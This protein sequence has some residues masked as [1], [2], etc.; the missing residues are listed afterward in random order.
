[1]KDSSPQ[2]AAAAARRGRTGHPSPSQQQQ[3]RWTP[4]LQLAAGEEKTV[5]QQRQL[6]LGTVKSE[7]IDSNINMTRRFSDYPMNVGHVI[8][9][10]PAPPPPPPPVH[11]GSTSFLNPPALVMPTTTTNG[12]QRYH[13]APSSLLHSLCSLNNY[14]DLHHGSFPQA[15]GTALDSCR[16]RISTSLMPP[17]FFSDG[18]LPAITE[19]MIDTSD[20]KLTNTGTATNLETEFDQYMCNMNPTD[21]G[22]RA[23]L[24]AAAMIEQQSGKSELANWQVPSDDVLLPEDPFES[25]FPSLKNRSSHNNNAHQLRDA[26]R[27]LDVDESN[28]CSPTTLGMAVH[29]MMSSED[30]ESNISGT[31]EVANYGSYGSQAPAM[32]SRDDSFL[33]SDTLTSLEFLPTSHTGDMSDKHHYGIELGESKMSCETTQGPMRSRPAGAVAGS[34]KRHMSLPVAKTEMKSGLE[35]VAFVV[36]VPSYGTRAKR[37]C[38]THPRSIAERVRRTRISDRMKKLQQVVPNM[39]KQTNTSEMLDEAVE[40]VKS[41]Q[42]MVQELTNTVAELRGQNY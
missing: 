29:S 20:Q 9:E 28:T 25:L 40:Y 42:K 22:R 13:S 24:S 5:F 23:A 8:L 41:L 10:C 21:F 1:M 39:V 38:A 19:Q 26:A 4:L 3:Q 2:V 37:G 7:V 34:L 12:F 6:E 33:L 27:Q 17:G 30:Q 31:S 32:F 11:H 35:D 18:Q 16:S 15:S 36:S 14:E